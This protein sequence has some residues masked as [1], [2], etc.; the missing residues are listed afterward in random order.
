[1]LGRDPAPSDGETKY[2]PEAPRYWQRAGKA[3]D[4]AHDRYKALAYKCIKCKEAP[5][6]EP[7]L[8]TALCNVKK[9]KTTAAANQFHPVFAGLQVE[10]YKV[11]PDP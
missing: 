11:F 4:D 3:T 7:D 5:L 1:M 10:V 8:L 6:D 2:Q 9:L